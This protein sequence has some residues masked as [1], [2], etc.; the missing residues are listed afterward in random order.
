MRWYMRGESMLRTWRSLPMLI[1][2][3]Y[4]VVDSQL[5]TNAADSAAQLARG[6]RVA[7]LL[8][9]LTEEFWVD[10]IRE[11]ANS[12]QP[13][14][15]SWSGRS[16]AVETTG[17]QPGADFY[18]K[19]GDR[20]CAVPPPCKCGFNKA[21]RPCCQHK[22]MAWANGGCGAAWYRPMQGRGEG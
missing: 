21:G 18:S 12:G 4:S 5:L 10:T 17:S 15:P 19:G 7:P 1:V 14:H 11:A 22:P 13:K 2:D 6:S 8:A 3:D 20:C 9:P 16:V